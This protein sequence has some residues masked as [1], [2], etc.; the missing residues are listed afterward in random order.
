[1]GKDGIEEGHNGSSGCGI[2]VA[3]KH[4]INKT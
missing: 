1:M 2:V 3:I 4:T